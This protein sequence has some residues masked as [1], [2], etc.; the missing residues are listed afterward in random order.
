MNVSGVAAL[1]RRLPP[2]APEAVCRGGRHRQAKLT[3]MLLFVI[4]LPRKQYTAFLAARTAA[5]A[6]QPRTFLEPSLTAAPPPSFTQG[7]GSEGSSFRLS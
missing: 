1:P 4:G 2:A 5:R 6:T 7:R 3:F